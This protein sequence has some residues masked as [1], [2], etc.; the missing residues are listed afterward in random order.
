MKKDNELLIER[1]RSILSQKEGLFS[2]R[3]MFGSVC[4][5]LNGNICVGAWKGSLLARLGK[6]KQDQ[7]LA[8]PHTKPAYI[9]SG[10]VMTGWFLI[11]P[12]G[13]ET[14]DDLKQWVN[15]SIKFTKS[16]PSKWP[17]LSS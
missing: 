12:D 14:D 16:L 17:T 10:R 11:E 6:E 1:I 3:K 8:E 15:K 4:F 9:G 2:E 5:M 13:I 7:V